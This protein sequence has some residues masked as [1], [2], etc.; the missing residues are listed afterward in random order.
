MTSDEIK[1]LFT[2]LDNYQLIDVL[3]KYGHELT[4]V[5]RDAYQV[6]GQ[7]VEFPEWLRVIN[8]VMHRIFPAISE[9]NND[10]KHRFAIE[11]LAHWISC[12]DRN[13]KLQKSSLAAFKYALD[14]A[15]LD[16]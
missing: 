10:T 15:R 8:E 11:S 12:E 1:E 16:L 4:V 5:A 3:S 7:G 2:R 6:Q 13:P 9:L 14:K